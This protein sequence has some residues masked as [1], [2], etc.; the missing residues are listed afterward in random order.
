MKEIEEHNNQGI[1]ENL[2]ENSKEIQKD[3]LEE[4]IKETNEESQNPT[5][6]KKQD[7]MFIHEIYDRLPFTYKQVD[8]F[9]KV[10]I[11]FTIAFV[12]ILIIISN[13]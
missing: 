12:I 9:T 11:G 13:I 6:E 3:Y 1:V 7:K 8:F 10:L 5:T 4:H 2:N